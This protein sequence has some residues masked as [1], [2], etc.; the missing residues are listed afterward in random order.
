MEAGIR[1]LLTGG[2][3]CALLLTGIPRTQAQGPVITKSDAAE[4]AGAV[5]GAGALIVLGIYFAVH[6]NHSISGCATAVAGG[7][8]LETDDRTY[9]LI[10]NAPEVKAG[11]RVKLA[12]KKERAVAGAPRPFFVEKVTRD[13]GACTAHAAQ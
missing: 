5:V 7:V 11:D 13:Y 3:F 1:R 6:R 9:T 8:Q 12:G 10:G 4:A 2:V